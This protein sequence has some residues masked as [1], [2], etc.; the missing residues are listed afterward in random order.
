MK[1]NTI[2]DLLSFIKMA[3]YMTEKK[4]AKKILK[5][6][7]NGELLGDSKI[8]Y[9]ISIKNTKPSDKLF[10]QTLEEKYK[11]WISTKGKPTQ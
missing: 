6:K 2:K 11:V 10:I 7:K 3:L 8:G 9:T 1:F 4:A 5:W